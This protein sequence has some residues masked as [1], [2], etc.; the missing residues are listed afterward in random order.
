MAARLRLFGTE[1]R[2]ERIDLAERHRSGFDVELTGLRQ[3]GLLFEVVHGKQRGGSFAGSGGQDGWI[4]E[5][6]SVAVE[7]IAGGANDFRAHPQDGCLT[8]RAQPKM[9]VLH[10]EID[11]V[12]FG[13]D[14]VGSGLGHALHDLDVR[15][16]ELITAG[17]ALIGADLAFDD[18]AGFLGEAF[19]GVENFGRDGV[20][21]DYTLD[22]AGAVAKLREQ[23]LAAFAE[24]V[25]PSA[26]GDGLAFVLAD[27][28]DGAYG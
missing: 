21:R 25:E 20:L 19:D 1:G 22:D 9:A 23:E 14:G 13:S 18:D 28:C 3:V 12:F 11:A 2:A 5:R 10:Q 24:V 17:G 27:S 15:D 6:E 7:K 16:V 4:G 26:D 8:L